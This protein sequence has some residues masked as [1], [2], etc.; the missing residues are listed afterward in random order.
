MD[1]PEAWG[2]WLIDRDDVDSRVPESVVPADWQ[3]KTSAEIRRAMAEPDLH[4][5]FARAG[6][7]G[8]LEDLLNWKHWTMDHIALQ[9][10]EQKGEVGDICNG[11]TARINNFSVQLQW[12]N[13]KGRYIANY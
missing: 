5:F 13:T 8:P 11:Q 4:R 2:G 12:S 10:N 3:G 7:Q 9:I 1:I 6:A